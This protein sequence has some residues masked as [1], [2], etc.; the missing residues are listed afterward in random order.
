MASVLPVLAS[1]CFKLPQG[2]PRAH[3]HGH[4]S[5][6]PP[7]PP[8]LGAIIEFIADDSDAASTLSA[9]LGLWAT[10]TAKD[11]FA[12]RGPPPLEPVLNPVQGQRAK[13]R[14]AA[15]AKTAVVKKVEASSASHI[16]P[17][18][19]A[20]GNGQIFIKTLTGK[21]ITLDVHSSDTIE[22]IKQKV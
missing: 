7:H 16:Y 5:I 14:T 13:V 8:F 1:A 15:K 2:R 3:P 21:C 20:F 22:L 12:H 4:R 18:Y 9:A 17:P 19:T 6:W 10:M 11:E